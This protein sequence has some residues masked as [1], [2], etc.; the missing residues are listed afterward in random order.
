[1]PV[2]HQRASQKTLLTCLNSQN[3]AADNGNQ[4]QVCLFCLNKPFG[5]TTADILSRKSTGVITLM[6]VRIYLSVLILEP[7][8]RWNAAILMLLCMSTDHVVVQTTLRPVSTYKNITLISEV[9]SKLQHTGVVLRVQVMQSRDGE[10]SV[11]GSYMASAPVT[12]ESM[13]KF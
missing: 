3:M 13:K 10:D 6:I 8:N 12:S 11:S 2:P 7:Y 5:F 9:L 1:M 4:L